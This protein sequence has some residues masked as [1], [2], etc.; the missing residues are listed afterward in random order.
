M[1]TIVLVHGSWLGGWVWH[2]VRPTLEAAGHRVLA[3]SLTGM[4]DRH[5]LAGPDVGLQ[6]HVADIANLLDWED[7]ADVTL[8]GH[9][10]GGMVI[11][12]VLGATPRRVGRA[13]YVDAF[14]PNDGQSAF[15]L[16]PWLADAFG[17]GPAD[18]P[19]AVPP[20]DFAGLGVDEPADLD[21]LAAHATPMPRA[22]HTEAVPPGGAG[23]RATL[24]V[25]Y[26][27]CTRLPFFDDTAKTAAAAGIRVVPMD[28]GHLPMVTNPDGVAA[29]LLDALEES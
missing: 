8:V 16:L 11:T 22:T 19:W 3:P 21:W 10:Y 9:S 4:A 15:D 27:H 20:L 24:P 23:R 17:T 12:G 6:V 18:R 13:V 5:H 25:T 26:I 1:G 14:M 7:L 29:A 28:A 2:R